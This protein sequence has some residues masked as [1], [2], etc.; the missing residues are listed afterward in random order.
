[1]IAKHKKFIKA[2][3]KQDAKTQL[4]FF[5][6]L[7]LFIKNPYAKELNTHPLKGN[8]NHLQSFDVTSDIRVHF[9]IQDD[10]K[11]NSLDGIS[12]SWKPGQVRT[13]RI[14]TNQMLEC[15]SINVLS[16]GYTVKQGIGAN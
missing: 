14:Q 5:E 13:F 3:K 12:G 11:F 10:A 9:Y 15:R 16:S 4:K 1:M 8:M 2:F 7:N 6:K